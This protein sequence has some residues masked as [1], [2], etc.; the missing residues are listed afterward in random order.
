MPT[1]IPNSAV[2]SAMYETL[3]AVASAVSLIQMFRWPFETGFPS[4]SL[5]ASASSFVPAASPG[6][7]AD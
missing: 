6:L 1:T 3:S 7:S 5:A 4:S 2:C